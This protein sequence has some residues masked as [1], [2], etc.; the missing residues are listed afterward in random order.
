MLSINNVDTYQR[1]RRHIVK[2][3][4]TNIVRAA[5]LLEDAFEVVIKLKATNNKP[6]VGVMI[7]GLEKNVK[8]LNEIIRTELKETY[9][10]ESKLWYYLD[11]FLKVLID[12]YFWILLNI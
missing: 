8:E 5:R 1:E 7:E 4:E 12:F 6:R 10:K 11:I 2:S 3:H 9:L